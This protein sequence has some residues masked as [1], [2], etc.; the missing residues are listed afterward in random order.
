LQIYAVTITIRI[1][2]SVLIVEG[3]DVMM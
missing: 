1:V 3:R 2:V